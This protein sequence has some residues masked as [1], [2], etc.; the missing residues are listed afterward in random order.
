MS[1]DKIL[2]RVNSPLDLKTLTLQEMN[3]LAEEIRQLIIEVVSRNGGHLAPNLGVVELTIALHRVFDSPKDKLIFDV[4]HQAYIHKILTGRKDAFP[5]LRQYKGLSGFPKRQESEHDAFGVGHS[6]TSLSAADGI[7]AARD[8][9]GGDFNVVAVIGDGAMTGGMSFEALNHIGDTKR[10]LIIVLN[11]NEMSISKN[12]GAMSRYLYQLRTGE[13]YNKLKRNM[14][15]WLSGLSHGDDVLEV[16]D[17]VKGGVKYLVAP[18]SMFEHLGIKYFGPVDGHDIEALLPMLV[19][20]KKEEGPVLIHVI[21]KKGKGYAPAEERANEF[22]GTGP[23]D[24]ATGKKITKPGAP[25]SYTE[26]FGRTLVELAEKDD[27][28]VTITA[29]MPDGTGTNKFAKAFPERFFDVGIA[30]QHAVTFAAGLAAEGIKP[31]VAIYSTFV[32]RAYDQ[33]LHDICMQN[34]PVKLCMDRGGLVGDDGYTHHGV[35]DYA[36]LIPMPNMTV[37]APKDENELRHMLLTAM[38]YNDGPVS[39]R[40]PRGSGVGADISE[41]LHTLPIGKAERLRDGDDLAIWAIGSMVPEAERT[42]AIL[43]DKGI[44]AGVVNM[45]FAKPLDEEMLARD[46]AETHRIVTM[47]E[48]V[49][50]GGVGEAVMQALN[51]H[52]L[53]QATAILTFGIPDKFVSQG[54][55]KL[56]M[57]DIGLAPEQMAE[58]IATWMQNSPEKA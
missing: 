38:E 54:D 49:V 52:N 21:T 22:H 31:V 37:M 19:A 50:L 40:Y 29:A 7:A 3:Q 24:I 41:P 25:P 5:T 56:L 6:S 27:K 28:I 9:K 1:Q 4:G 34:L 57:H 17:R 51:R 32:Q 10:R 42:A 14:E 43:K 16:I 18:E 48:G 53:L 58:Q 47:E 23:F 55:K 46:A 15:N 12:V 44:N 30:E 39:L 8:L 2:D 35:F 26:V 20:A 11:D 36:Y 33:V 13:T 45:R